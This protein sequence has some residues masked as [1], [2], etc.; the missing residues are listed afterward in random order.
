MNQLQIKSR[1]VRHQPQNI[2]LL[3]YIPADTL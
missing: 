1:K 3:T 2:V